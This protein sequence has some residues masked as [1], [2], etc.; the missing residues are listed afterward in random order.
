[1]LVRLLLCSA[2]QLAT[3]STTF[4][5]ASAGSISSSPN[6]VDIDSYFRPDE[7]KKIAQR[8]QMLQMHYQGWWSIDGS[9]D[10]FFGQSLQEDGSGK[11]LQFTL[12]KGEVIKGWED[13]VAGMCVGEKRVVIVPPA[14][15]FGEKDGGGHIP[16]GATLKL[17]LELLGAQDVFNRNSK[18]AAHTKSMK[19]VFDRLDFNSDGKLSQDELYRHI[20]N[21]GQGHV[22]FAS[23]LMD[24]LHGPQFSKSDKDGDGLL[25]FAEWHPHG[26]L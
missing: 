6:L 22:D 1:M 3:W 16:S 23:E 9:D 12:G 7:C 18:R 5:L 26:E 19:K 10:T 8:G 14:L 21:D 4:V 13:G 17:D 15:A 2:L 24:V 20:S 11:P 25:S